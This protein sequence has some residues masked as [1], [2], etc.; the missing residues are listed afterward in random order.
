MLEEGFISILFFFGIYCI[1]KDYSKKNRVWIT[2]GICI[3]F[4]VLLYILYL[5]K[6]PRE[7]FIDG[8]ETCGTSGQTCSADAPFCLIT[9]KTLPENTFDQ[10]IVFNTYGRYISIYPSGDGTPVSISQL[11]VYGPAKY[12]IEIPDEIYN[13]GPGAPID[14]SYTGPKVGKVGNTL[15]Y[16]ANVQLNPPGS[17]QWDPSSSFRWWLTPPGGDAQENPDNRSSNFSFIPTQVGTYKIQLF[18]K[19]NCYSPSSCPQKVLYVVVSEGE[20]DC[21][22]PTQV[23]V[24]GIRSPPESVPFTVSGDMCIQNCPA[25]YDDF[26]DNSCVNWNPPGGGV[27]QVYKRD[28]ITVPRVRK[29]Q[30]DINN[31]YTNISAY[32]EKSLIAPCDGNAKDSANQAAK[33]LADVSTGARKWPDIWRSTTADR[34]T[35]VWKLNLGSMQMITKIRFVG[36]AGSS[37]NKGIRF[38]ITNDMGEISPVYTPIDPTQGMCI[39][40]P[41]PIYPNGTTEIE[42]RAIRT[43]ILYGVNPEVAL[44]VFRGLVNSTM[45]RS[46]TSFG[47]TDEQSA[48]AFVKLQTALLT[49]QRNAGS[50]DDNTYFD[51]INSIKGVKK[52]DDIMFNTMN[53]VILYRDLN[54]QDY[55]VP[56][57]MGGVNTTPDYGEY[58]ATQLILS[59]LMPESVDPT[60]SAVKGIDTSPSASLDITS[61]IQSEPT[62]VSKEWGKGILSE[63]N[64]PKTGIQIPTQES[65]NIGINWSADQIQAAI[66]GRGATK[67]GALTISTDDSTRRSFLMNT[68]YAAPNRE[69]SALSSTLEGAQTREGPLKEV[70]WLGPSQ[71]SGYD[72][73]SNA[74]QACIDAG[75]DGLATKGDLDAAQ[76][77]GA[78]WCVYG[79][80]KDGT[81][82]F[83]MKSMYTNC[84]EIGV[85]T[86]ESCKG[87]CPSSN[88]SGAICYGMKPK[89]D[90]QA[91]FTILPFTYDRDTNGTVSTVWNQKDSYDTARCKPGYIKKSCRYDGNVKDVCVSP[92]QTC[93]D[94]CQGP[95]GRTAT[96]QQFCNIG[97]DAATP[98]KNR[99]GVDSEPAP[100]PPNTLSG[101]SNLFKVA[102]SGRSKKITSADTDLAAI[103]KSVFLGRMLRTATFTPTTD[104]KQDMYV[105]GYGN[106]IIVFR[107]TT[108]GDLQLSR[109]VVLDS[110]G[111][112]YGLK[113][114][115]GNSTRIPGTNGDIVPLQR[116]YD[117]SVANA[118]V[119]AGEYYWSNNKLFEY[120]LS[121][122]R[123]VT[124]NVI[125]R[126][127][128]NIYY[129]PNSGNDTTAKICKKIQPLRMDNKAMAYT[130][131]DG[132]WM[133]SIAGWDPTNLITPYIDG[134]RITFASQDPESMGTISSYSGANIGVIVM[135]ADTVSISD[136]DYYLL[137]ASVYAKSDIAQQ[138]GE[139]W[140]SDKYDATPTNQSS[141]NMLRVASNPASSI[142]TVL[143]ACGLSQGT[144]DPN[145][146]TKLEKFC[147]MTDGKYILSSNSGTFSVVYSQ[148][149]DAA[150]KNFASNQGYN[151]RLA[152]AISAEGSAKNARD[153]A[154]G[155]VDTIQ[156]SID[157][158]EIRLNAYLEKEFCIYAD[159]DQYG[160]PLEYETVA[161]LSIPK[162]VLHKA[163]VTS[164]DWQTSPI[165]SKTK[166]SMD[167][168]PFMQVT[169]WIST[170]IPYYEETKKQIAP[171]SDKMKTLNAAIDAYTKAKATRIQI[172]TGGNDANKMAA[173]READT[174]QAVVDS[175]NSKIA[176]IQSY[177]D[178]N[179]NNPA[180]DPLHDAIMNIVN[181]KRQD[182]SQAKTELTAANATLQSARAKAGL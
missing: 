66:A 11:S 147:K 12:I 51:S 77:A 148:A 167:G 54:H 43:P 177:I 86:S 165:V 121:D 52:M 161:G 15:T 104:I 38:Q 92:G 176:A 81:K 26:N 170:N 72:T 107:N 117:W 70:F 49:Q 13:T 130:Q 114:E 19:I 180:T 32:R 128:N 158:M 55:N 171:D 169:K 168:T 179:S 131:K 4:A 57:G 96:G 174:A 42:K 63:I 34:N 10:T 90:K 144:S 142:N 50:I 73:M 113:Q 18:A 68:K 149:W 138:F 105:G 124:N 116:L 140:T 110:N 28:L 75:A 127:D 5:L 2:S 74:N 115:Q 23:T 112:V 44:N 102:P 153:T 108:G 16:T 89:S 137:A 67:S 160:Q 143:Q 136:D 14:L 87:S 24:Y 58:K 152:D 178:N 84:G 119:K 159:F 135:T 80:L 98:G 129:E 41:T 37:N 83:P 31:N 91:G 78:Q 27:R 164:K 155:D 146:K 106:W 30:P 82:A 132:I 175:L 133:A 156:M 60:N 151:E 157:E 154:Q 99:R 17:A 173:I 39:P 93:D 36:E 76:A 97:T 69:R 145:M 22:P 1:V 101:I 100:V 120:V 21:P 35:P 172:Q 59:V 122:P 8:G 20:G 118:W 71:T 123:N 29:A 7:P 125:I 109:I 64:I 94:S 56:N 134:V 126:S 25:G 62:G 111:G 85:N 61:S 150:Q 88:T 163:C 40:T 141:L 65:V 181:Q 3:V 103:S 45:I 33:T 166:W 182:L 47:L 95:L 139:W 162:R 79:W 6:T 48:K 9:E 46:F 53:S